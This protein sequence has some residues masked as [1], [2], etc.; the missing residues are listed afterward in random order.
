MNNKNTNNCNHSNSNEVYIGK[1]APDFTMEAFLPDGTF[2]EVSLK[3]NKAANKW[4]IL[5]F[6]PADF[7]FVCPTEIRELSKL[8]KDFHA[9]NAEV[10]AVSV[11]S[12]FSHMHWF[13]GDLGRIE[14]PMASDK[15][16]KYAKLYRVYDDEKGVSWRGL[17]I[18]DPEGILW[19]QYVTNGEVGRN[20][21]E[22]LRLIRASKAAKDGKL[23]PC[24]WKPSDAFLKKNNSNT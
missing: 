22:A 14:H 2:G 20:A 17:F 13:K 18:I 21:E 6:Y 5:Y 12:T 19:A 10:I 11:D 1:Q 23:V 4:T 15:T 8:T 24:N 9:E 7:T 16:H 3:A